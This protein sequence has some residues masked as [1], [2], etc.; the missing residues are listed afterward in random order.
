MVK[1]EPIITIELTLPDIFHITDYI[2]PHT[3]TPIHSVA[4]TH[5]HTHT[6]TPCRSLAHTRTL[7]NMYTHAIM[8]T[9]HT[10]THIRLGTLPGIP[11]PPTSLSLSATITRSSSGIRQLVKLPSRWRGCTLTSS[12]PSLG[13]TMV[14]IWPPRV[15][16][17]RSGSL[18]HARRRL[19][20]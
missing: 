11:V 7:L 13:V 15:K 12:T 18:I 17:R 20:L 2:M 5:T 19:S 10:H 16:T 6:H 8:H 1:N 9:L 4:H 3:H 14:A